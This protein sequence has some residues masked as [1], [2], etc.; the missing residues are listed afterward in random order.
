MGE[1]KSF[2]H[3]YNVNKIV[4]LKSVVGGSSEKQNNN[5]EN[6]LMAKITT[7]KVFS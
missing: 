7:R 6:H 3:E 5:F 2:A 4:R 1:F